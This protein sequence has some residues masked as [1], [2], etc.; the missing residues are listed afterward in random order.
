MEYKGPLTWQA[1]LRKRVELL[2]ETFTPGTIVRL[3]KDVNNNIH[4]VGYRS[5]VLEDDEWEM[6]WNQP[7]YDD[8]LRGSENV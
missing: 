2:G 3:Q 5:A 4:I 8:L 7:A 6:F 1:I